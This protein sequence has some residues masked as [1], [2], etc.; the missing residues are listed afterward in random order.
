MQRNDQSGGQ[1]KVGHMKKHGIYIC[2]LLAL[3]ACK[4]TNHSN[5]S[6]HPCSVAN[7]AFSHK[8]G[9]IIGS[10]LLQSFRDYA[11]PN[12]MNGPWAPADCG[13]P[14]II[15]FKDDSIFSYNGNFSLSQENFDRFKMTD[16]QDFEIYSS[17]PP[18]GGPYHPLFG[19]VISVTQIEITDMGVDTGT[20]YNYDC[21]Q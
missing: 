9:D 11:A 21:N 17:N 4:K 5:D 14:V 20:E 1:T 15:E 16:Q 3:G 19:K 12:N 10:W 18:P 13:K 8:P 6:L 7:S 2:F